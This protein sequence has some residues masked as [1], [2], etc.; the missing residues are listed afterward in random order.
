[1]SKLST[2]GYAII[3]FILLNLLSNK[4]FTSYDFTEGQIYTL[5][6]ATD[7]I[8]QN[9]TKNVQIIAFVSEKLPPQA[10]SSKI[11][12]TDK[13]ADFTNLGSDKLTITYMDPVKD[14]AAADLAESFGIPPLDLQVIEKDQAQVIKAYF[15]LAIVTP[16]EGDIDQS[17][18][19]G[20]YDKKVVIPV[21]QDLNSLEYEISSALLKVGS[22]QLK[23]VAFLTGHGE[24]SFSMPQYVAAL[25]NDPRAD[26][27]VSE[28]LNRNYDVSTIDFSGLSDEEKQD[29][30]KNV[31]TLIVAGPQTAISDEEITKIQQFV[32]SGGNAILLIDSM[33][34]DTQYGFSASRLPVN[35]DTLLQPW[36]VKVLPAVLADSDNDLASFNQ[37]YITYT[38]PYPFFAKINNINTENAITR[39]VESFTLPWTSPLEVKEAGGVITQV[40]A[41]SS[42]KYQIFTE[43]DLTVPGEN[44]GEEKIQH[45]P[46]DISPQQNFN[47]TDSDPVPLLVLSQK[48][49]GGKVII[50][51][52]SDFV[53]QGGSDTLLF[54]NMVDGLTLG[55][56]LIEIRSKGVTDRPLEDLTSR[57]KDTIRWGITIGVPLLIIIYGF[58]RRSRRQQ[59]KL[60]H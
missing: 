31:D 60:S 35:F 29:P 45:Q 56:D 48:N 54:Y 44:E 9:L 12:L 19:A 10:I 1:M 32:E 25:N 15:G 6:P 24:H 41:S 23:K 21:V 16:A 18:P 13:L 20:K 28:E 51:G 30:F 14:T 3:V 58:Y 53:A 39:Q 40:L 2:I 27:P 57:E 17:D 34:I 49:E 7:R 47:L 50:A 33:N 46:I 52:D 36:G 59:L 22:D 55:N 26:Y 38:L 42:G 4:I 5:S 43:T 8:V 37:G 11:Q